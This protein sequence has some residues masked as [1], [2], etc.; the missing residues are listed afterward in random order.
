MENG[1]FYFCL[2]NCITGTDWVVN[3]F[4]QCGAIFWWVPQLQ[5]QF[6]R[7]FMSRDDFI[8]KIA[9]NGIAG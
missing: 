2:K 7:F 8:D 6:Q 1:N 9:Q 3:K 5:E 4:W